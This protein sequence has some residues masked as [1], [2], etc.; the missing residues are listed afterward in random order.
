MTSADAA[1]QRRRADRGQPHRQRRAAR[2]GRTTP[3]ARSSTP[4]SSTVMPGLTEFHSHLQ[5]DYGE[6]PG[7]RLARLRHHDRAQ[8]RQHALRSGRGPRGQ[9]GRRAPGP[10]RLRHR[11]PDGVEPRLLQDGHRHLERQPVRDGAAA[12]EGARARPDQELRAP[13]GS[14]SRS[15]WW[16]SR[17]SIGVPGGHARDLPGIVRRRGQHRAHRRPR[18]AAATRRRWRRCRRP[19]RTSCSCSARARASSAR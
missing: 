7:P 18:A 6:A 14:R 12:R 3:A 2:R 11:L 17:T 5:K 10:A 19:T 16:S 9:R 4:R 8:P 1:H 15:G 13:A